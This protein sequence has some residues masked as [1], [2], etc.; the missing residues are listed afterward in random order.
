MIQRP[1]KGGEFEYVKDVRD[2]D[3]GD[4]NFEMAG[5][6]L[7]GEMPTKT[8]SMNAGDLVLFRGRNSMHQVTPVEGG[9]ARILVVLAY[10]SEPGLS[11]SESARMTFFGRH[12]RP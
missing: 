2:A 9:I 7:D 5:K 4:M 1:E 3:S 10:N 6:I 12:S 8:L 11:L